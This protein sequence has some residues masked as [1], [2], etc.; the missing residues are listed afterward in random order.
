MVKTR[1]NTALDK[2]EHKPKKFRNIDQNE[3]SS[4]YRLEWVVATQQ[5][6]SLHRYANTSMQ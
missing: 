2:L 1:A 4:Q 6:A 5:C 3:R